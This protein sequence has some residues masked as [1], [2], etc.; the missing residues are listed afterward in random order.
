[1]LSISSRPP[2]DFKNALFFTNSQA[3][4]FSD[5]GQRKHQRPKQDR[6][7]F[8]V[9]L[10]LISESLFQ[11]SSFDEAVSE[12]GVMT[13]ETNNNKSFLLCLEH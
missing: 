6:N 5:G 1:M 3:T 8:A 10:D 13:E 7:S 12:F 9:Q 4:Q 2:K 11:K